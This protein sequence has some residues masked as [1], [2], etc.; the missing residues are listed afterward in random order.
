M[1]YT[2]IKVTGLFL[3]LGILGC[4]SSAKT[5][6]NPT[7]I[8]NIQGITGPGP[9]GNFLK[10]VAIEY[11]ENVDGSMLNPADFRISVEENNYT[12][13]YVDMTVSRIYT[14]S[15]AEM[16]PDGTSQSGTFVIVETDHME[17]DPSN[18]PGHMNQTYYF[19]GG[20]RSTWVRKNLNIR[21]TQGDDVYTPGGK[22]ISAGSETA[23]DNTKPTRN[24]GFE[25]FEYIHMSDGDLGITN[26]SGNHGIELFYH[27]PDNYN[28]SNK[29]PVFIFFHGSGETFWH[30]QPGT[31]NLGAGLVTNMLPYYWIN[32]EDYGYE[33]VIF[34]APQ[35]IDGNSG[36]L[37]DGY[38]RDV[39]ALGVF[40]YVYG[41]KGVFGGVDTDRIYI[42]GTSQGGGRCS[43]LLAGRSDKIAASVV[44]NS[45]ME[46]GVSGPPWEFPYSLD[47]T[48]HV[49]ILNDV[50][51]NGTAVWI[52]QGTNDQ[53]VNV[54]L[55]R[56]MYQTIHDLHT[57]NR[58]PAAWIADNLRYTE[59]GNE[60]YDDMHETSY[61][62][63]IKPTYKWFVIY[64]AA[65]PYT[66]G[67]TALPT[68]ISITLK[69]GTPSGRVR[70]IVSQPYNDLAYKGMMDWVFSKRKSGQA[71]SK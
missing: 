63:S 8:R 65:F 11:G 67:T 43:V 35:Y 1:K 66:Y 58:R 33:D 61:H 53:S 68:N 14:N 45:F 7:G 9:F 32:T 60:I 10:A 22:V 17:A 31:D 36:P 26:G 41:K 20:K 6:V 12:H 62:S 59:M 29:Y 46:G 47:Y 56:T 57:A 54:Q 19:P 40:D 16:R 30:N 44:Q 27:L 37:L 69:D 24:L 55:P 23:F 28:P 25:E 70:T 2:L 71:L 49:A 13:E 5:I 39:A 21:V 3:A 18:R 48:W 51:R 42:S 34:V 52:F 4:T 50:A 15:T 64:D 38:N